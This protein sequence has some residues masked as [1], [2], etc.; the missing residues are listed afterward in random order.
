MG[1]RS[2]VTIIMYPSADHRDKFAAL[3]LYVDENL[4]D[5][6]EVIGEGDRR[7][8]H[9]YI[10]GVKWYDSYEEVDTYSK[11]FSEWDELFADP[12]DPSAKEG[13]QADTI[14]QYE[15]MRI[16]EDYEDVEYHQSYGADHALN[17]SREVYIDL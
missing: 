10:D 5:E 16:G 8:L 14:F 7:Y 2:D 11:L 6:F 17:M 3:K 13:L 1:Y 12:D 4:P 15:F 9:C